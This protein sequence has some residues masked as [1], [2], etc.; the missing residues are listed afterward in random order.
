MQSIVYTA[1]H[2]TT[3]FMVGVNAAKTFNQFYEHEK[4]IGYTKDQLK[5]A[6]SLIKKAAGKEA[7]PEQ[8]KEEAKPE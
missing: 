1:G 6:Y 8:P 2:L 4:H 7:E 5:E 3:K